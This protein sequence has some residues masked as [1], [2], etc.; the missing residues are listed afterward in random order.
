LVFISAERL[1]TLKQVVDCAEGG[2]GAADIN[3]DTFSLSYCWKNSAMGLAVF[4]LLLK[5][6]LL[7]APEYATP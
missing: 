5:L 7:T 1:L 2:Y 3:L 4:Q 6:S